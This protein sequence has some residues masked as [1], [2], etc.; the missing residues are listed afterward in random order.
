[1]SSEV[2]ALVD[3][4]VADAEFDPARVWP[5]VVDA[6][7]PL[8][9]VSEADGGSGGGPA[10]L[11]AI[12]RR[13]GYHAIKTPIASASAS[14]RA[15]SAG[16]V[17]S[18]WA[19]LLQL[20]ELVGCVEGTVAITRAHL[21]QREQ[22]GAPLLD[23]PTV[24]TTLAEMQVEAVQA[25]A[26]LERC[27]DRP[28]DGAAL[29]GGHVVAAAAATVVSH[30]A[31]RLHGA[32]GLTEEHPLHRYTMLLWDYRDRPRPAVADATALGRLAVEGGPAAVWDSLTAW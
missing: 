25:G 3:S 24:R 1:M 14:A 27:V 7:L 11:V 26:A 21:R 13:L 12:V 4:I 32:I 19:E 31:H 5:V 10:D 6:G 9:G 29:A 22:F 18:G 23:L 30:T 8:V 17:S 20:A 28:G 15:A 16:A 2:L